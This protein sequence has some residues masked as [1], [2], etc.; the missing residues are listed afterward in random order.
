MR[1]SVKILITLIILTLSANSNGQFKTGY[2]ITLKNDTIHGLISDRGEISNSKVCIFEAT[3][4]SKRIKYYPDMIKS[5]RF[6][7]DKYY[8]AKQIFYK[9]EFKHVFLE[10]I[11]EGKYTLYYDCRNKNMKF[12]IQKNIADLIGLVKEVY[13]IKPETD[14]THLTYMDTHEIIVNAFK[15]TL[16][17]IFSNSK[18]TLKHINDIE[19]NSESLVN[20]TKEYILETCSQKDCITYEKNFNL[21][22]K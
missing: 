20:I 17:S 2:L 12:Y 19:Y 3:R 9:D 13:N 5:Y 21:L 16:A 1:Y 6:I 22:K 8:I 15:D 4:N 18:E 14:L 11:L 7:D 10:V